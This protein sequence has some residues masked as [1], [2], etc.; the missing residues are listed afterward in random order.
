MFDVDHLVIWIS[1]HVK[2]VDKRDACNVNYKGNVY[3]PSFF[4]NFLDDTPDLV[5]YLHCV[6]EATYPPSDSIRMKVVH[7]A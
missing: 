3:R 2:K 6:V 5:E 7:T 4:R 1:R